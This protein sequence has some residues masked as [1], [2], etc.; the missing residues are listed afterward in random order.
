MNL[1]KLTN[2]CV[3]FTMLCGTQRILIFDC[4]AAFEG[5]FS[6]RK[7]GQVDYDNEDVKVGG[8][9]STGDAGHVMTS[10]VQY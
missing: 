10:R 4:Y 7:L 9:P 2:K 1:V 3:Y 6:F 8:T 5:R